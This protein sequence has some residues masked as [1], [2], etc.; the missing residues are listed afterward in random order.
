[1]VNA[2]LAAVVAFV[3]VA[4]VPGFFTGVGIRADWYIPAVI[5]FALLVVRDHITGY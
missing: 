2:P 5:V 3:L 4:L 1:M